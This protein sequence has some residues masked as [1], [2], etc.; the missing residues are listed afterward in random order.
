MIVE[1]R[2]IIIPALNSFCGVPVIM[3]DQTGEPP[4]GPHVTFKLTSQYLKDNGGAN[5]VYEDGVSFNQKLIEQFKCVISF[6][7]IADD[8]DTVDS[9][10]SKVYEW[11]DFNGEEL[12]STNQIVL[13]DRSAIQNRDA[14]LLDEYQRKSG[15][16]VTLRL[17]RELVQ[18][19]QYI[20]TVKLSNQVIDIDGKIII[21]GTY[22]IG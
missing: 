3:A 2:N 1:A 17:S 18:E 6:T 22:N 21:N 5:I 19:I 16:D 8:A 7:A 10:A 14:L 12:L 9:L 20:D 15:F 4:T 11:F 13:V